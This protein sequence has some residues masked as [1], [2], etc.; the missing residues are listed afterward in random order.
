MLPKAGDWKSRGNADIQ[1]REGASVH[2]VKRVIPG[3][4][5][6]PVRPGVGAD[7]HLR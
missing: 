6:R 7:L 1:T 5:R 3:V 2:N 4:E